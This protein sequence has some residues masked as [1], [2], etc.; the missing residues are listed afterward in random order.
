MAPNAATADLALA[1]PPQLVAA[2]DARGALR[3]S[4]VLVEVAR[5]VS[6]RSAAESV[7]EL[8]E[9]IPAPA[10][11]KVVVV[12]RG[13][14]PAI[15]VLQRIGSTA[16]PAWCGNVTGAGL[17][18]LDADRAVLVGPE[19]ASGRVTAHRDGSLLRQR[20][21]FDI[22]GELAPAV[23]LDEP[24][25]TWR[26]ATLNEYSIRLEPVANVGA[27]VPATPMS[28]TVIIE[29][30]RPHC[31]VRF[32]TGQRWH[33]AAPLTGLVE[34]VVAAREVPAIARA[35]GT[36]GF[37]SLP[38]GRVERLPPVSVTQRSIT[39]DFEARRYELIPAAS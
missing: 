3:T 34:L 20:W 35:L 30:A 1:S 8:A 29:P 22:D 13:R 16:V 17:V 18:A 28:K 27:L 39:I 10:T 31:R 19:G 9:A 26:S 15:A 21:Q 12:R 32:H 36:S 7:L 11:G 23:R 5:T 2:F 6:T 33:G 24:V 38:D 4:G 25:P 37:V 14:N